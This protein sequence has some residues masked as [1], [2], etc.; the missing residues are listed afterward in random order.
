MNLF[1]TLISSAQTASPGGAPR[2]TMVPVDHL[3]EDQTNTRELRDVEALAQGIFAMGLDNPL[4]VRPAPDSPAGYYK[5]I[6]G[7]RRLAA[8][9]LCIEW[10]DPYA[11][12]ANGIPCINKGEQGETA[13]HLHLILNNRLHREPT[14]YEEMIETAQLSQMDAAELRQELKLNN[15]GGAQPAKTRDV[16]ASLLKISPA[17][18]AKYLAIYRH[19]PPERMEDYKAGRI[20]T[21][22]AYGIVNDILKQTRKPKPPA[23]TSTSPAEPTPAPVFGRNTK[24]VPAERPE[25]PVCLGAY[26]MRCGNADCDNNYGDPCPDWQDCEFFSQSQTVR[27]TP[28]SGAVQASDK[29]QLAVTMHQIAKQMRTNPEPKQ[30]MERIKCLIDQHAPAEWRQQMQSLLG[31]MWDSYEE[32]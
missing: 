5:I 13:A 11:F 28:P 26:A 15:P 4:T 2:I 22:A 20:G 9:R 32:K 23:I 24:G 1:D 21:E 31:A 27:P 6:A 17:K 3:I 30:I 7:H 14:G 10:G 8:C 25:P 29:N 16:I 18:T 19:L 12:A